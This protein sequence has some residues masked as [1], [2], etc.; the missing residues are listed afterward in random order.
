MVNNQKIC[1]MLGLATKAGKVVAGREA[2]LQELEKHNIKLLVLAVDSAERTKNMFKLKCNKFNINICENLTID[3][4]S[5]S[6]GKPNK[7]IVGIKDKS[8]A[9][10]IN[11]IINGG[12]MIG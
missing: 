10:A 3:E 6:I 1:G 7:A 5:N 8:F 11:K 4:I 2:C 9:K 12:E